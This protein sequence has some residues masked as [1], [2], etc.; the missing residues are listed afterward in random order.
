MKRKKKESAFKIGGLLGK[1]SG[2]NFRSKAHLEGGHINNAIQN[3]KAKNK[4]NIS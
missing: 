4:F 1:E 3:V 2:H